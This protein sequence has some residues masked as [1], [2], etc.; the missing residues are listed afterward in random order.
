MGPVF[1]T[2]DINLFIHYLLFNTSCSN[3]ITIRNGL[4]VQDSD[5]SAQ[6]E[7]D[8]MVKRGIVLRCLPM[9]LDEDPVCRYTRMKK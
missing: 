4:L 1:L 2:L 5:I 3:K 6:D 7:P 8:I 9:I